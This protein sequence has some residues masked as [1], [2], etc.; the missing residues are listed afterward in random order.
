MSSFASGLHQSKASL[1]ELATMGDR[2]WDT[3]KQEVP[4]K[5]ADLFKEFFINEVEYCALLTRILKCSYSPVIKEIESNLSL[6]A[7][8]AIL[9]HEVYK[10]KISR[11]I[12]D[13]R[14]FEEL[15][16]LNLKVINCTFA[17]EESGML[18]PTS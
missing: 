2:V 12:H 18:V 16:L 6:S 14:G 10:D 8:L 17:R 1:D 7:S 11:L 3:I 13:A 5:Q 15:S 4:V 9:A